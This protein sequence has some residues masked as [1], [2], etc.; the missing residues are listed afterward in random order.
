MKKYADVHDLFVVEQKKIDDSKKYLICYRNHKNQYIEI[1]TDEKLENV[2]D[3]KVKVLYNYHELLAPYGFKLGY[4]LKLTVKEILELYVALNVEIYT[5]SQE[6]NEDEI[7]SILNQATENF[8]PKDGHWYGSCFRRPKDVSMINLPCHLRDDA[9]LAQ[10]FYKNQELN[11]LSRKRVFEYVQM[12]PVFKEARHNYE[13]KIVKWQI[14]WIMGHGE[15]WICDE[16]YGG[17]FVYLTPVVDLGVR[18]G[19]VDTLIKIG[20]D[21]DVIEE[22]IEK[23]ASLWREQC[24]SAAFRNSFEP[25][26]YM[27]KRQPEPPS[28]EHK[29]KWLQM[30]R[31]EYYQRHK[32]SVDKYGTVTKDM[33]LRGQELENLKIYLEKENLRRKGYLDGFKAHY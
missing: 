22:G 32:N 27:S 2:S 1:L 21:K 30:R 20:M 11:Q 6:K 17:D 18:K 9:W 16:D 4:A 19:V 23:Y 3:N 26:Y 8:F 14:E 29:E 33:L 10:M 25:V 24:M 15:N 31:Y 5:Q 12:S 13:L 28:E 7:E